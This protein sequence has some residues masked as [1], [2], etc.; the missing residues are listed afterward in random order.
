M[1]FINDQ[2]RHTFFL[3]VVAAC[4]LSLF[5]FPLA[6]GSDHSTEAAA[7]ARRVN[8]RL[9]KTTGD[10]PSARGGGKWVALGTKLVMFGGFYEC[11]DK[12]KCEHTY[13]DDVHILDVATN[14][15]EKR[16]PTSPTGALPGNR[17][18]LGAA[19]YKKKNTAIFFGGAEYN[20]KVTSYQVYG[21][22][23]EYDPVTNRMV[24]R[25]YANEG[26]SP[27]LGAE[28]VITGDT[29]YLFGGYD[30]SFKAH[31]ELWSY[32]LVTNTWKQLRKDNDPRSPSKRYIFR[33]ELSPSEE[34]IYIFGGNYREKFTIQRSDT[35]RYNIATDTFIEIVSEQKTN[36]T[37]RTHGTCAFA[38]K[39]FLIALGDI[40]SG[41]CFT[42]QDS[43]HQNPTNEVWKLRAGSSRWDRV[44]IGFGPPPL[45]RMYYATA[46]GRLYV[47]HGFDYQCDKPGAEGPLYNLNTYSLP[48][49]QI[50]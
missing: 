38:G 32:D 40:P 27:R 36:I 20:A 25:S 23:W 29:L 47:T 3:P 44:K 49:R 50:R 12:D 48:L 21:D 11:F 18:F 7:Q 41:G 5:L 22:L 9:E 4:V 26:P 13:F 35:W 46:G 17:V 19:A 31:N 2:I 1:R 39:T 45:K 24:K 6:P 16:I 10:N 28:I 42:N 33:F 37:G 43:E 15:W 8:W 14:R 34:D 30:Q